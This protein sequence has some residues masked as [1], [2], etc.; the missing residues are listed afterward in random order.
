MS[1]ISINGLFEFVWLWGLTVGTTFSCSEF[2]MIR[3]G[4]LLCI[5]RRG[6]AYRNVYQ[7][8]CG[9]RLFCVT[10]RINVIDTTLETSTHQG[11]AG[12]SNLERFMHLRQV[13]HGRGAY[14]RQDNLLRYLWSLPQEG[15]SSQG[16]TISPILVILA[17]NQLMQVDSK[18]GKRVKCGRLL[19]THA[20]L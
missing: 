8:F 16:D 19:S 11:K 10:Y 3:L 4:T 15:R 6:R 18:D 17:L 7:L 13:W 5:T 2:C 12:R 20:R 14:W 9:F 1:S